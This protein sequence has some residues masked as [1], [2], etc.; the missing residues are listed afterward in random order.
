MTPEQR[1]THAAVLRDLVQDAATEARPE[2]TDARVFACLAGAAALAQPPTCGTC[3]FWTQTWPG[4]NPTRGRCENH[5]APA[6]DSETTADDGC[7]KGYAP[8]EPTR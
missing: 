5:Q 3:K 8:T 4:I 2:M 7:I 1:E 6:C